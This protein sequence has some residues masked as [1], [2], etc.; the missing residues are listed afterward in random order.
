MTSP[1]YEP[2]RKLATTDGVELFDCGQVALN[3]F[4]LSDAVQD[5]IYL[6]NARRVLKLKA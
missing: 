4:L 5:K 6:T 1:K 2:V 3:Q